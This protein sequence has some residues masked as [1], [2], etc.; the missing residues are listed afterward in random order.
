MQ[1]NVIDKTTAAVDPGLLFQRVA[2][3]ER[4]V[5]RCRSPRKTVASSY[6]D[7]LALIG[8]VF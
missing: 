1:V 6:A 7:P 3:F 4:A 5:V 8:L 2:L